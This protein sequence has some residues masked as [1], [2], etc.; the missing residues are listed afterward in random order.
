MTG[1]RDGI[2]NNVTLNRGVAQKID[3][4]RKFSHKNYF[5][6]VNLLSENDCVV[7]KE[8]IAHSNPS[9]QS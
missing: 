6:K 7:P 5:F 8:E 3:F 2:T 1:K 4:S 9:Q